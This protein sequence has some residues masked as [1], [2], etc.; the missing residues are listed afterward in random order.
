MAVRI[1]LNTNDALRSHNE[2]LTPLLVIPVLIVETHI[3]RRSEV[4]NHNTVRVHH[5]NR[6]TAIT[7]TITPR[8]T[9][10]PVAVIVRH[11]HIVHRMDGEAE[12]AF[13][14]LLVE[15]SRVSQTELFKAL[16][17]E[18]LSNLAENLHRLAAVLNLNCLAIRSLDSE[19][20]AS[21]LISY[22]AV[23]TEQVHD[24]PAV[25]F[26]FTPVVVNI[27]AT[28][29]VELPHRLLVIASIHRVADFTLHIA[30]FLGN[31]N[32]LRE[33]EV[34]TEHSEEVFLIGVP[35]TEN[36]TERCTAVVTVH[37]ISRVVRN[38]R[39]DKFLVFLAQN[40]FV[41]IH[42]IYLTFFLLSLSYIYIITYFYKKI[43]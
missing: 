8:H 1:T 15:N 38:P 31:H 25:A 37:F 2:E 17:A 12:F 22:K 27:V 4:S 28:S 11:S 26:H 40:F 21:P 36:V 32:L 5:L 10:V 18:H 6:T 33:N 43:K 16:N 41:H 24:I 35:V 39:L 14:H 13:H 20:V 19:V 7:T 23:R 29:I 3:F 42:S 9:R 30:I 34:A